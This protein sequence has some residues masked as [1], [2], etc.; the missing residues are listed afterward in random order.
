MSSGLTDLV[1]ASRAVAATSGDPMRVLS[2]TEEAL[3]RSWTLLRESGSLLSAT[4][5][6][7]EERDAEL[8]PLGRGVQESLHK[9]QSAIPGQREVEEAIQ[10]ITTTSLTLEKYGQRGVG[11]KNY[12]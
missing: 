1:Q 5:V 8:Q 7:A 4:S 11:E 3:E 12:G 2:A 6:S 9:I 10:N